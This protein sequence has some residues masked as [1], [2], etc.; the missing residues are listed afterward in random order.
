[1]IP[2]NG[3]HR[4]WG[5]LIL[6]YPASH[7]RQIT[8]QERDHITNSAHRI[9]RLLDEIGP[10]TVPE[11]PR[12]VPIARAD[13]DEPPPSRAAS[14]FAKRLPGGSFTLD[15]QGRIT[16]ATAGAAHLLGLAAHQL[17]DTTPWHALPWLR[18]PL[19]MEHYRIA[20][21]NREPV[22]FTAMRPP[23]RWLTFQLYPD[24]DGIS[25]RIAPAARSDGAQPA[26]ADAAETIKPAPVTAPASRIFQLMHFAAAL[27]EAVSVEDVLRLIASQILPAFEAQ[28]LMLCEAEAGRLKVSGSFGTPRKSPR[29]STACRSTPIS[30]R[31]GRY[32]PAAFRP[33]IPRAKRWNRSSPTPSP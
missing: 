13:M 4:G 2:V 9:A 29:A 1:M 27:T 22:A 23:D 33:S 8:A 17:I 28:S 15:L 24:S 31:P 26:T 20:A 16:F 32:S 14:D 7:P 11:Q 5:V 18:D 6:Y 12:S 21:I 25:V 19:Y 30:H 3:A 10:G